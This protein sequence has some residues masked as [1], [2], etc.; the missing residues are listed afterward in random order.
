MLKDKRFL[1]LLSSLCQVDG[2]AISNNQD[3]VADLFLLIEDEDDPSSDTEGEFQRQ[4]IPVE[5]RGGKYYAVFTEPEITKKN[6]GK[7]LKI[8][9]GQLEQ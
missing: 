4:L 6:N 1:E 9:I 7:S 8:E 3:T 5:G 2:Q